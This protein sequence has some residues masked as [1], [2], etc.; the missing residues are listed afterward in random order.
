MGTPWGAFCQITLTCCSCVLIEKKLW[1]CVYLYAGCPSVVLTACKIIISYLVSI[2]LSCM[3]TALFSTCSVDVLF[4]CIVGIAVVRDVR[5]TENLF[6]FGLKSRT[7]QKFDLHSDCFP[8]EC[9]LQFKLKVTK[10]HFA[11]IQCA[12]KER[13][14]TRPKQ[15]VFGSS[16]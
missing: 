15:S 11:C 9:S 13:F 14:K 7:V 4:W 2:Y 16:I 3:S 10:T 1:L 8:T 5:K 12:D 6:G